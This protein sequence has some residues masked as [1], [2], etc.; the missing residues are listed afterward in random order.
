[1]HGMWTYLYLHD[2][3]RL[4]SEPL[5]HTGISGFSYLLAKC[6]EDTTLG[7]SFS[8]VKAVKKVWG[9]SP[10]SNLFFGTICMST[11]W[12]NI[13][14]HKT[15]DR[16]VRGV[17]KTKCFPFALQSGRLTVKFN[18]F[19]GSRLWSISMVP[20]RVVVLKRFVAQ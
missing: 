5:I 20:S 11:R 7:G 17:V 3:G 10:L 2:I 9:F 16:R 1:M 6:S 14:V 8:F 15:V 12:A 4:T 13:I 19:L 18:H